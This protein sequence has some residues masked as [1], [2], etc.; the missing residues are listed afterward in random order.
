[1]TMRKDEL[2]IRMISLEDM[3]PYAWYRGVCRNATIAQ[4][5]PNKKKFIYIR[6]K[7]G[8]QLLETIN[9]MEDDNGFDCFI[10]LSR[11]EE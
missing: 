8:G 3:Q 6:H 9:H 4:W 1:M 2:K 5:L 7:F 11:I 10:P